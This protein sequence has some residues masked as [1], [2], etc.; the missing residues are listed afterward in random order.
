MVKKVL[1]WIKEHLWLFKLIFIASVLFFVVNQLTNI[2]QGMTWN[3]FIHLIL[4]QG[5]LS[6]ALMVIVGLIAASPMILYDVATTKTLGL[7]LPKWQLIKDG[8]IINT[9]NNLVGFGGV[10]GVTLRMNRYGKE[11]K[12]AQTLA[13]ITKTA[14]FM[15]TGLSL[16]CFIMLLIVWFVPSEAVY[17]HY[18]WWLIGGS[19]FAPLLGLVIRLKH[20]FFREFTKKTL[21]LFYLASFGQWL[22]AL[23]VFLFIGSEVVKTA[24]VIQ[25]APLFIVATLIGMLTMVPGG[26][27]T[28]DVLMILGLASLGVNKEV[29]LVWLLFYR[30][31]YYVVP[32]VSGFI[33]FLHQAGDKMN[34]A[35]NKWPSVLLSKGAHLFLTLILYSSGL[36]MIL[37]STL[38]NLSMLSRF[39]NWLLP[40]SFNFFDQ[41]INMMMG[42]LLIG[43][44]R[45]V[46]Q[47]VKR[48]YGATIIVLFVCLLNTIIATHSW[49]LILLF[50]ITILV[51]YWSRKEFT[52]QHFVYS[53]GALL[54]DSLLFIAVA[55]FYGLVG[56]FVNTHHQF[57]TPNF[58][59]FP[60]ERIWLQGLIGLMIAV[61][62]IISLYYY[63]S[64]DKQIGVP[65]EAPRFHAMTKKYGES[66]TAHLAYLNAYRFYYYQVDDEDVVCFMFVTI[67]NHCFVLGNPI[68]E[69]RYI[70]EAVEAFKTEIAWHNYQAVFYNITHEFSVMLHDLGYE[71]MKIGEEGYH[72]VDER[73]DTVSPCT[74]WLTRDDI[75]NM[76]PQ[77]Q[78]LSQDFESL[79]RP[80]YFNRAYFT[81][82]FVEES[83]VMAYFKNDELVGYS[84]LSNDYHDTMALM[85]LHYTDDQIVANF[86]ADIQALLEEK[87]FA[88]SLGLSP[89]S[90]V[91]TSD[92][93]FREE[94]LI[95]LVYSI[96]NQTS[97]VE[98]INHAMTP[99]VN[100]WESRYVS[101]PRHQ[102][103]IF[104]L[105]Q[106]V[107]LMLRRKKA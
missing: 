80:L 8:W 37:L 21:A 20:N 100:D 74:K 95:N 92:F 12:G 7:S 35:L 23:C 13:T 91:G 96:G 57:E 49:Q 17:R 56:Y 29:A 105:L 31:F 6:I 16:L 47:R 102:S 30:L 36:T 53:W 64:R 11:K 79:H 9:I 83:Q 18:Q 42:L 1:R 66:S 58:F 2:L 71:F 10:V 94:K 76:M 90:N 70:K 39:F 14:L 88:L 15:L 33:L 25:I 103:F 104:L 73:I 27:G 54:F 63:L 26:I 85:Y 72:R 24:S 98:R 65:Y 44:A 40:Y 4:N 106:V 59:L 5:V 101:Y 99:Y 68:G 38:P 3:K 50:T 55:I 75:I 62:L 34:K 93:A 84:V 82:Q 52:R 48:A 87:G 22:G 69:E 28:F 61:I 67:A 46:Y 78:S 81:P 97:Y 86:I 45:G 60:S 77:L 107:V 41:T 89:L 43:L 51:V 32:F 19:L